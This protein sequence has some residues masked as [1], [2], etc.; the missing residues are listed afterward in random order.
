M[1][2]DL[3]HNIAIISV[4]FS[5]TM[6]LLVNNPVVNWHEVAFLFSDFI[7]QNRDYTEI[8][9]FI[10]HNFIYI[11]Q[12][13]I[14]YYVIRN[15]AGSF[16]MFWIMKLYMM[17]FDISV[18][19][20]FRRQKYQHSDNYFKCHTL[21]YSN[22]SNIDQH[23]V[24]KAYNLLLSLWTNV[25][26]FLETALLFIYCLFFKIDLFLLPLLLI[27]IALYLN[28]WRLRKAVN[29]NMDEETKLILIF[30]G[31]SNK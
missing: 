2:R 24:E 20:S 8:R 26:L 22:L 9:D 3:M 29:E 1:H 28:N 5:L 23:Y 19:S 16:I 6:Q 18:Q 13:I 10:M 12:S 15:L 11:L 7:S 4:Y 17:K 27:L 14:V 30:L 25:F 31:E 21:F